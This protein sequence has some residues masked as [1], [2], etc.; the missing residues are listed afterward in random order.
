[1]KKRIGVYVCQCGSNISDYVDVE[2]V[3]EEAEKDNSV[4]LAKTTMFACAD[5]AQNEIIEDI[6]KNNLD[7]IVIASCS[8]KLHLQT[9]RGVATR[10]GLNPY[11]YVQV[12]IREQ[13]SWPHSD[14]PP[15]ATE[16]A[17][18]L[19][20]AGIARVGESEALTQIKITAEN[21]AAVIGAGVSGMR[22][23]IELADMGTSVTLV[24]REHF[25][26]GR[27][28]QWGNLFTSEE[29]G[30]EIVGLLYREILK[31]SN[32]TLYT[33]AEV[34]S[35]SGSVGNFEL[36]VKVIPRRVKVDCN[37][38]GIHKAIEICPVEVDDE[39]NFNM[40]K[41]KAIY[42]NYKSEFPA[43]P[44]L[45]S[46]NCTFCGDCLK[47]C[48]EI[49]LE[50]KDEL[51]KISVGSILLHTGFDPYTPKDGEYSFNENKDVITLQQFKRLIE[52]NNDSLL[53]NDKKIN[54]IGFIYCVGSRQYNGE[55]KYCSRYC[56]TSAIHSALQV[57]EKF[58]KIK[59]YHINRGIRTYGKQE[60]LYEES[61][62]QGDIY[63]Q[64]FE[65]EEPLVEKSGKD[66]IIKVVD[67]LTAKRE[68]EIAVDLVVLVTGMVPRKDNSIANLLKVPIGRDK[69]FNEV[70]PKLRPVETVIDGIQIAGACQ[71]PKNITETMKSS[72]SAAAKANS[73]ISKGEIELEPTLAKINY[74]SCEWCGK[75]AAAC[76]YDAISKSELDKKEIAIINESSCKGCGMCLPVCPTDAIELIGY[77]NKEI[78]SMIDALID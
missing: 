74:N 52:L 10:A 33:G 38:P 11:N 62:K 29:T 68:L 57:K 24:E 37:T 65:D 26:G 49:D 5:S 1:M 44:A 14:N 45:D 72:L 73:L 7:G 39:F 13:C 3:K 23:A 77:T 19:V 75:C 43:Y 25:V 42:K 12:N 40:T 56:C 27:T 31:H 15:F 8:P 53:Y 16:K 35:K 18:S 47:V 66:N 50:Q 30:E 71:S 78:E 6:Q 55:N 54:S 22:C 59:C 28:A 32:I 41:R 58:G 51:V 9:F 69:F 60:V 76:P 64:F 36:E 61:S 2:K 4:F 70:H 46:K 17:I 34:V 67:S 20:K 48:S 63:I 21:S